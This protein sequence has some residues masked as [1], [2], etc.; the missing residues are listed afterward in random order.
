M[1][2]SG[3]TDSVLDIIRILRKTHRG[4]GEISRLQAWLDPSHWQKHGQPNPCMK[5]GYNFK[6]RAD[7]GY[8]QTLQ[9]LPLEQ[10]LPGKHP[11]YATTLR[12][13]IGDCSTMFNYGVNDCYVT[14]KQYHKTLATDVSA[15][16]PMH[17]RAYLAIHACEEFKKMIGNAQN[18][19]T[20]ET[21]KG[22][23]SDIVRPFTSENEPVRIESVQEIEHVLKSFLHECMKR[24]ETKYASNADLKGKFLELKANYR[25]FLFAEEDDEDAKLANDR[26]SEG[27][28]KLK[29]EILA[30]ES[31][32]FSPSASIKRPLE[33]VIMH[34]QN[35]SFQEVVSFGKY[36]YSQRTALF[37]ILLH[38]FDSSFRKRCTDERDFVHFLLQTEKDQEMG[39]NGNF[40]FGVGLIMEWARRRFYRVEGLVQ[41]E[42]AGKLCYDRLHANVRIDQSGSAMGQEQAVLEQCYAENHYRDIIQGGV[43]RWCYHKGGQVPGRFLSR[44]RATKVDLV[45]GMHDRQMLKEEECL[46]EIVCLFME[47]ALPDE[48]MR[49]DGQENRV[50][51]LPFLIRKFMDV[52][53]ISQLAKV[54]M[55][56]DVFDPEDFQNPLARIRLYDYLTASTVLMAGTSQLYY[57]EYNNLEKSS[58]VNETYLHWCKTAKGHAQQRRQG[59]AKKPEVHDFLAT[60]WY[61]F[62]RAARNVDEVEFLQR[63]FTALDQSP[64]C[65]ERIEDRVDFLEELE[66]CG[67]QRITSAEYGLPRF[68]GPKALGQDWFTYLQDHKASKSK[69]MR[70]L[71]ELKG[72]WSSRR[73]HHQ[74]DFSLLCES[75][76][77]GLKWASGVLT[78]IDKTTMHSQRILK[79]IAK[80]NFSRA[81]NGILIGFPESYSE[82]TDVYCE[83]MHEWLN[84]LACILSKSA[85]H[86]SECRP[87][88]TESTCIYS[89][90]PIFKIQQ[91]AVIMLKQSVK[92]ELFYDL[93]KTL[94]IASGMETFPEFR[95][96][97]ANVNSEFR[98]QSNLDVSQFSNEVI[99][100]LSRLIPLMHNLVRNA[101]FVEQKVILPKNEFAARVVSV[102]LNSSALLEIRENDFQD[103]LNHGRKR[104]QLS[105]ELA[106]VSLAEIKELFVE[107]SE[108]VINSLDEQFFQCIGK[109]VAFDSHQGCSSITERALAIM[110]AFINKVVRGD[111]VINITAQFKYFD[112]DG[113]GNITRKEFSEALSKP[114]YN[115][116]LSSQALKSLVSKFDRD[117]DDEV[118]YGEFVRFVFD[119]ERTQQEQNRMESKH[120]GGSKNNAYE[121]ADEVEEE[122]RNVLSIVSGRTRQQ[123]VMHQQLLSCV[124]TV[125]CKILVD[126]TK[127]LY[128]ESLGKWNVTRNIFSILS[129]VLKNEPS[130][131]HK[132]IFTAQQRLLN[133]FFRDRTLQKSLIGSITILCTSCVQLEYQ[134]KTMLPVNFFQSGGL[135]QQ[136]GGEDERQA[137]ESMTAEG[138]E[139]LLLILDSTLPPGTSPYEVIKNAKLKVSLLTQPVIPSNQ[140]LDDTSMWKQ[141]NLGHNANAPNLLLN[142]GNWN[143]L[144]AISSYLGYDCSRQTKIPVLAMKIIRAVSNIMTKT[145][146]PSY[147]NTPEDEKLNSELQSDTKTYSS[148]IVSLDKDKH[149]FKTLLLAC[150]ERDIFLGSDEHVR[151][152]QEEILCF[153]CREVSDQPSIVGLVLDKSMLRTIRANINES[154]WQIRKGQGK[155]YMDDV[156]TLK[157][158]RVYARTLALFSALWHAQSK[159]RFRTVVDLLRGEKQE[160]KQFWEDVTMSLFSLDGVYDVAA[161]TSSLEWDGD[162]LDARSFALELF[163]LEYYTGKSVEAMER[164]KEKVKGKAMNGSRTYLEIWC[165]EFAKFSFEQRDLDDLHTSALNL[166]L[167]LHPYQ[168]RRSKVPGQRDYGKSYIYDYSKLSFALDDAVDSSAAYKFLEKIKRFNFAGSK[169]DGQLWLL[170][171]CRRFVESYCCLSRPVNAQSSST[172]LVRRSSLTEGP[173]NLGAGNTSMKMLKI[174]SKEL[175]NKKLGGRRHDLAAYELSEWFLMMVFHQL[176]DHNTR[177]RRSAESELNCEDTLELLDNICDLTQRAF[178]QHEEDVSL[179]LPLLASSIMLYK[180]WCQIV[181]V[182]IEK[183][184]LAIENIHA[185]DYHT[186]VKAKVLGLLSRTSDTI[187][188][189]KVEELMTPFT[190]SFEM[191]GSQVEEQMRNMI[192][193]FKT[194]VINF[195]LK[196]YKDL[197]Q[198]ILSNACV[199][200]ENLAKTGSKVFSINKIT[201]ERIGKVFSAVL[202]EPKDDDDENKNDVASDGIFSKE[203]EE[204][205]RSLVIRTCCALLNSVLLEYGN[206]KYFDHMPH[207]RRKSFNEALNTFKKRGVFEHLS[208][209]LVSAFSSKYVV[210]TVSLR[211]ERATAARAYSVLQVYRAIACFEPAATH[212]LQSGVIELILNSPMLQNLDDLPRPAPGN[213]VNDIDT[214]RLDYDNSVRGYTRLRKRSF[215]HMSWCTAV[216]LMTEILRA[217]RM[218]MNLGGVQQDLDEKCLSLILHCITRYEKTFFW[219]IEPFGRGNKGERFTLASLQEMKSVMLLLYELV[220]IQTVAQRWVNYSPEQFRTLMRGVVRCVHALS[221]PLSKLQGASS[222]GRSYMR[223]HTLYVSE[224]EQRTFRK[225]KREQLRIMGERRRELLEYATFIGKNVQQR[226]ET[227]DRANQSADAEIKTVLWILEEDQDP[228]GSMKLTSVG[229][230]LGEDLINEIFN[231]F[232]TGGESDMNEGDENISIDEFQQTLEKIKNDPTN[233][234]GTLPRKLVKIKYLFDALQKKID[235]NRGNY[236]SIFSEFDVNNN[237][238]DKAEFVSGLKKLRLEGVKVDINSSNYDA[239]K[240]FN[241][242]KLRNAI[243]KNQI[244]K[245]RVF[246]DIRTR[247]YGLKSNTQSHGNDFEGVLERLGYPPKEK[248]GR[249]VYSICLPIVEGDER[250][251]GSVIAVLQVLSLNEQLIATK[252]TLQAASKSEDHDDHELFFSQKAQQISEYLKVNTGDRINFLDFQKKEERAFPAEIIYIHNNGEQGYMYDVRM[253]DYFFKRVETQACDILRAAMMILT[254][255]CITPQNIETERGLIDTPGAISLFEYTPKGLSLERDRDGFYKWQPALE[256]LFFIARY[257]LQ[258]LETPSYSTNDEFGGNGDQIKELM[259]QS[260][261]LIW[262]N[263]SRAHSLMENLANNLRSKQAKD[264]NTRELGMMKHFEDG[265]KHFKI[266]FKV[267]CKRLDRLVK[268][269]PVYKSDWQHWVNILQEFEKRHFPP[270]IQMQQ[271][272]LEYNYPQGKASKNIPGMEKRIVPRY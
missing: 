83:F 263:A 35:V 64:N 188:V 254:Q 3:P 14:Y 77:Y 108:L 87:L 236:R 41:E 235:Q 22:Y 110:Y 5:M 182:V 66:K 1:P 101:E 146:V 80:R 115:L 11:K 174:L 142:T 137:I 46:S 232:D 147:L 102:F 159:G 124:V 78:A 38:V 30:K 6:P 189:K 221:L 181:G 128:K 68:P 252:R 262:N 220:R 90:S 164:I 39:T 114:P 58:E 168:S 251:P 91:L 199:C 191:A 52:L 216:D 116:T 104:G 217:R 227:D 60:I 141:S 72:E 240:V 180:H 50:Y 249:P 150:L 149:Q 62:K 28:R 31:F 201:V 113:S 43:P 65:L 268:R 226:V 250:S 7:S 171:R 200:I 131:L 2:E 187:D 247:L 123:F 239:V 133:N 111:T 120:V 86:E 67:L 160:Q 129:L 267:V 158:P 109:V 73:T 135:L 44:D 204:L 165:E 127:W 4:P 82:D 202:N 27:A 88:V 172:L 20:I 15:C 229:E 167:N 23:L 26:L 18:K 169:S 260:L 84:I 270:L 206:A 153:L 179:R 25:I 93:C 42:N 152:L 49:G 207:R 186:A 184:N 271:Q 224:E 96:L 261:Y 145:R 139:I 231:F 75:S 195:L 255:N 48:N 210:G 219:A 258:E 264:L 246:S 253:E 70:A 192:P 117:G 230:S 99:E 238:I 45:K 16:E 21:A 222:A 136:C 154:A 143:Q 209:V 126:H 269:G 34:F 148:L 177:P 242:E 223:K 225:C 29:A 166:G 183:L 85:A 176:Y 94:S 196:D 98:R 157:F 256:H 156:K 89:C 140:N 244:D 228:N 10:D 17:L 197:G 33:N 71:L 193:S 105:M 173:T 259:E 92:N 257:C 132:D 198:R 8:E 144:V 272:Q 233:E 61:S 245:S 36:Y 40:H 119:T 19:V 56:E 57:H 162:V 79:C 55:P 155:R 53:R 214:L 54:Q 134:K 218:V 24:L 100:N 161:E 194:A 32:E 213:I 47:K 241:Q 175:K 266:A 51:L 112:D 130:G 9:N 59:I 190:Q 203:S 248:S 37:D 125:A 118:D 74:M 95:T 106:I 97:P 138:F 151:Q 205:G 63:A 237:S 69:F 265:K 215:V 185:T 122:I 107:D 234:K 211:F 243:L 103:I 76:L 208:G 12:K 170:K 178:A 121:V 81:F 212:L 163:A 13:F